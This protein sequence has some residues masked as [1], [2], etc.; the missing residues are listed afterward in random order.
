MEIFLILLTVEVVEVVEAAR[1]D[2][3][4]GRKKWGLEAGRRVTVKVSV[5]ARRFSFMATVE[6]RLLRLAREVDYLMAGSTWSK[7]SSWPVERMEAGCQ[8]L[9]LGWPICL[10]A[11]TLTVSREA[12]RSPM[13]PMSPM[14]PRSPMVE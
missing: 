2:S 10:R 5:L 7:E 1:S 11:A 4:G 13:A 14:A 9:L 12:P 6:A 8:P 3:M